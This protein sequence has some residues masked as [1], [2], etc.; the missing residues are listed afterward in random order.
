VSVNSSTTSDIDVLL[1]TGHP[2]SDSTS[3]ATVGITLD[4]RL[5]GI[6]PNVGS[7]GGTRIVAEVRGVGLLT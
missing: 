7:L 4:P 3:L 5:N 2:G 6:R 1:P